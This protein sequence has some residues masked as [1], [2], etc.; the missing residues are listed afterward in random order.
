MTRLFSGKTRVLLVTEGVIIGILSL[1]ERHF[2]LKNST[3]Q[4]KDA[5][6]VHIEICLI[7]LAVLRQLCNNSELL[8]SSK[9]SGVYRRPSCPK[10]GS[11]R[12]FAA[13]S[14]GPKNS[15]CRVMR[16]GS[17]SES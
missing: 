4:S 16:C 15:W 13:F 5:I 1:L 8:L 9:V 6:D 2:S 12:M 3:G 7:S 10:S 11:P 17:A 14:N